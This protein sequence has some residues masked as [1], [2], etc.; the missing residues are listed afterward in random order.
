MGKIIVVF[1]DEKRFTK[2]DLCRRVDRKDTAEA[3]LASLI[4][5]V[6]IE[7]EGLRQIYFFLKSEVDELDKLLLHS[8]EK[9][10]PS[11]PNVLWAQNHWKDTFALLKSMYKNGQ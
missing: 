10:C 5:E 9:Y 2:M 4:K 3:F 6:R 8:P 7:G 11:W 1:T